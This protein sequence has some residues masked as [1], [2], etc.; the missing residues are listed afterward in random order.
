ML[1]GRY[2]DSG[3]ARFYSQSIS[4]RHTAA[5]EW[6]Y[7]HGKNTSTAPASRAAIKAGKALV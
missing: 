6:E 1:K 3:H 5:P 4:A 7:Q 2:F